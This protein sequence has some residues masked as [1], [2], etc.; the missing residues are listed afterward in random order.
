MKFS[1]K[2]TDRLPSTNTFLKE[3]IELDSQLPSGTLVATREQ[4]QGKGRRGRVWLS[5]ANE[6]LTFSV[7]IRGDAEPQKLPAAAMAAAISIAELVEKQGVKADLKWPNDVLAGGKKICGILSEGAS[8]GIIVGIG[9]NV[10][11]PNAD[12]I[13]QPATSLLMETGERSNIND[14]LASLLPILSDRLDEWAEGGF[15]RVRKNWEAKV[16]NIGKEISVRD[17]NAVREGLLAGFG[18]NGELLLQDKTGTVSPVW[19]GDVSL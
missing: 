7:F 19:A 17:G 10:N 4:T 3:W 16:P 9:L 1:I 5:S 11:M 14:L 13:D 8:G 15:S 6:N 12:H 18:E 2:W